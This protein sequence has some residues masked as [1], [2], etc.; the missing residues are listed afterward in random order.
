MFNK[1]TFLL[2]FLLIIAVAT[3]SSASAADL[4]DDAAI[5]SS[6]DGIEVDENEV[7]DG[8]IAEDALSQADT[9][10]GDGSEVSDDA[11]VLLMDESSE[12]ESFDG[13]SFLD[14][15]VTIN[16]QFAGSTITLEDDYYWAE[17]FEGADGIFI[18]DAIT[19]NGNG[20]SLD[21]RGNSRIFLIYADNVVLNNIT[22]VNGYGSTNGGNGGCICTFNNYTTIKNCNF[23]YNKATK[24][25]GAI[26]TTGR[27]NLDNCYFYY[28][29]AD[30]YGG[31]ILAYCPQTEAISL[32]INNC[33][34]E[35]NWAYYGGAIYNYYYTGNGWV[36]MDALAKTYLKNTKFIYNEAQ[37]GGALF[38]SQ[39][40]DIDSCEF[41]S[42]YASGGGG[43]IYMAAGVL[44]SNDDG[45]IGFAKPMSLNIHGDT[46]FI[47]NYAEYYG[48]AI[49]IGS[50]DS[51][52][53]AGIK[54]ILRVS[55]NVLFQSNYGEGPGG[56]LSLDR[57]DSIVEDARFINNT[58]EYDGSAMYGGTAINC[59]FEGNT[60]P[61]T[62]D[63][64]VINTVKGKLTISQSGSYYKGKTITVTLTN[65]NT[66]A[67]LSGK[68]VTIKFSNGKSAKVTTNS[69]G[70]ATYNVPFTPGT[71]TAT[72]TVTS[73]G[74][75]ASSAKL[76]NIKISKAPITITPTK[77]ST[78]Y[79]S[80]KY[81]QVKVVNS[82]TKK[83]V[84]GAKLKLKVYT[85][86]KAKTVTV[87]TNSK[88]IAKYNTGKLA[89]GTHKVIVTN[90]Q[91]AYFTGAKKTSSIKI[92]KASYNIVAPKVTNVYKK[93]GSFKITVKN[94]ASGKAVSGVKLTVKVYTGSKYKTYNVKTNSK[95]V[96]T[97]STKALSKGTH[98]IA[99]STKAT[100]KYKAAKKSSSA[101]IVNKIP[102]SISYVP[103]LIFYATNDGYHSHTYRVVIQVVLTDNAGN[104]LIKPVTL[105][106]SDGYSASGNSG[107]SISVDGGRPGTVTLIFAGDSKYSASSYVVNL[108]NE[109]F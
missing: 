67:A 52:V 88:G 60:D 101:K 69:N 102:T 53:S 3:I 11:D 85:G 34:F 21:A 91:T 7:I 62:Y 78:T 25:G 55:G 79:A 74:V 36:P 20:H 48:G 14:L 90:G 84:S 37:Y 70:K 68:E 61:A 107:S 29:N 26:A 58:A 56:A 40:V 98:K 4:T 38:P 10:S 73:K 50:G 5:D 86:K 83:V 45:S 104:E 35:E 18:R 65:A 12:D 100:T 24:C 9:E 8:G 94:K 109:P 46:S 99:I 72:A 75:D 95:G 22:F 63:T 27:L 32:N 15:Q 31:A 92:T 33:T 17:D 43:A 97:I 44:L 80:G 28:N 96:A 51:Y 106:H 64:E 93:A 82:K 59:I 39:E 42:N 41:L 49:R 105:K 6:Y 103:G 2:L 71:Y 108:G 23:M 13:K 66:G 16:N 76:S 89:M 77:L 57:T 47:D 30:S 19:I 54:G 1:R 87:T 81:F